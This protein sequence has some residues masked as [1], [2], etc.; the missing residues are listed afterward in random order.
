MTER[1]VYYRVSLDGF[2]DDTFGPEDQD[3]EDRR[4]WDRERSWDC[5]KWR[6]GA[7]VREARAAGKSPLI[8]EVG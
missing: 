3:P 6:H 7:G 1:T 2:P 8:E 5:Y 4:P